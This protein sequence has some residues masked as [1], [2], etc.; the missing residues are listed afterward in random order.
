MMQMGARLRVGIAKVWAETSTFSPERI[1][2]QDLE[3]NGLQ[4]GS[5][6]LDC[7]RNTAELG[8]FMAAAAKRAG[9][10][11]LVPLIHA[12]GWTGGVLSSKAMDTIEEGLALEMKEAGQLDGFYF[13][14]HG[15]MASEDI[16][17]VSGYLLSLV[18][19]RIG[20]SVPLV[21]S[22][23]H[24]ANMTRRILANVNA[25]TAY[26]HAPHI[27]MFETGERAGE[28]LFDLMSEQISPTVAWR[29]IPLVTPSYMYTTVRTPLKELFSQARKLEEQPGVLEILT[30]QVFPH[31]DVPELGWSTVAITRGNK[32]QAQSLADE[33]AR[34]SWAIRAAMFPE[35]L[36]P[37]TA[38]REACDREGPVLLV[39]GAD[40]V[41]GGAPGNSTWILQALLETEMHKPALITIVDR[42]AV[43]DAI[44]VG[45][46]KEIEL[47]VG[48]EPDHISGGRVRLGGRITR[49][50][51][52]RFRIS[53]HGAGNVNMGRTVLL[54]KDHV[55]VV[56]SERPGPGH[57]P[58]VY[59]HLGLDP[60]T[61]QIV[62]VKCT[63]GHTVVYQSIMKSDIF[64]NSPGLTPNDLTELEWSKVPRP[65]YP[66]DELG[67][68]E[69]CQA[70]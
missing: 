24:H 21:A 44:A 17:D 31:M 50:S 40:N 38:I 53:G 55:K 69:P 37:E 3:A 56:I 48:S 46:G 70:L 61:A 65:L 47:E 51:D 43:A 28:M 14:L 19:R 32:E 68:W 23:D 52:G 2:L 33:M 13:A 26:R 59:R 54:E 41:N 57:D 1:T 67:A 34:Q 29:K 45:V 49:I 66:I 36:D 20:D 62:V 64:V 10:V 12:N 4:L 16:D 5:E 30:F 8:G 22:F 42:G 25:L 9:S 15:A 7:Y 60:A 35:T 11:E 27:D 58:A 18:R 63:A 39:D 6:I